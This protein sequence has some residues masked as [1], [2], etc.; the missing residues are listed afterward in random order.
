M[1]DGKEEKGRDPRTPRGAARRGG[2]KHRS[3]PGQHPIELRRKAVQLLVEESLPRDLVAEELGVSAATLG[4]WLGRY[5]EAGEAGLLRRPPCLG[6]GKLH[7]APAVHQAIVTVKREHPAFGVRRI[8]QWLRRALLLPGSAETV[9]QTL[10]RHDLLP[11][12]R[13]KPAK[14]NPPKPRFFERRTPNQLWQSD[15]FTFRL[16]GQNAYLIGF[17]DDHSRYL[18][19][20][21]VFRSQTAENVLEVYRR[22]VGAYGVPKEM[23]TDNGKQYAAWQGK[24]RF[25]MELAKDRIHHIRSAPHHPMTL[26]KI[27]RFWKTIWE[28]F[29]ERARFETF[30]SAVERIG[31]WVKYYNHQRPHQGIEGLCPAD[32]FFGI[33]KE[34]REAVE[35]GIEANVQELA[36]RGKP[37]TP[38]YMVGRVGQQNVVLQAE[39]GQVH[40]LVDG[41]DAEAGRHEH[42]GEAETGTAGVQRPG[43]VPSGAGVVDGPPPALGA[44]PG[45]EHPEPPAQRLAGTGNCGYAQRAGAAHPSAG[46]TRADAASADGETAGAQ[47]GAAGE[48]DRPLGRESPAGG[49]RPGETDGVTVWP[50]A[51]RSP[52][53]TDA[54][55]HDTGHSP[56]VSRQPDRDRGG[57][58]T[59]DLPQD[60]LPAGGP[61]A[62][63]HEGGARSGPSGSPPVE[64]GR[65]DGAG[66]GAE[67]AAPAAGADA[68]AAVAHPAGVGGG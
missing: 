32:R 4:I 39:R 28:E 29:L 7:L 60:V 21:G 12:S 49:S 31:Y 38:F 3:P 27:E 53:A 5:Q 54:D 36:L 30:E 35:R 23:L 46:G 9:R 15:I 1:R 65:G 67:P 68:Q 34:V 25:Q 17:I 44:V 2:A 6:K 33:Q 19:G 16:N 62:G 51:E 63:G 10:H 26:G 42:G 66:A 22:A 61:G 20:L 11:K 58:A 59:G 45:H 55:G 8:A 24:T 56:A 40:I 64:A 52:D 47:A 13:P 57:P 37:Q 48:P 50:L 41:Q 14:R 43:E 18:T